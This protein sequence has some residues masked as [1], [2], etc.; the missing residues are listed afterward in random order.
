MTIIRTSRQALRLTFMTMLS[1]IIA[2][3]MTLISPLTPAHAAGWDP[4]APIQQDYCG[5]KWDRFMLDGDDYTGWRYASGGSLATDEW[6]YA[7]GAATVTVVAF[8]YMDPDRTFT[9]TFGNESDSLCKQAPDAVAIS[10]LRCNPESGRTGFTLHVANPTDWPQEDL[11][12]MLENVIN[13]ANTSA[14][15]P[16]VAKG[17]SISVPTRREFT[18]GFQPLPPGTYEVIIFI[19]GVQTNLGGSRVFI[20]ACGLFQVEPGDPSGKGGSASAKK[21]QPRITPWLA[22]PRLVKVRLDTHSVK[23]KTTCK[24]RVKA[25]GK[26]VVKTITLKSGKTKTVKAKFKKKVKKAKVKAVCTAN[27]KKHTVKKTLH[28]S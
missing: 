10:D 26:K 7:N 9:I 1:L 27:G 21:H 14:M 23:G 25:K 22:S 4:P 16:E 18:G 2:A 28:R 17:A 11:Q 20:P 5:T 24:V 3:A 8:N 19:N 6:H 12:V 13:Y 15:I